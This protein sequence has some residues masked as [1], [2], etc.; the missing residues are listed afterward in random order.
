MSEELPGGE[1]PPSQPARPGHQPPPPGPQPP[2]QPPP[3]GQQPPQPGHQQPFWHQ[4]S[5]WGPAAP[6]GGPGAHGGY[7]DY[8]WYGGGSAPSDGIGGGPGSPRTGLA[9]LLV[10]LLVVAAVAGVAIGYAAWHAPSRAPSPL[11]PP[12]T[13]PHSGEGTEAPG[14]P[15]DAGAIAR[16]T[17]PGLVDIDTVEGYQSTEGA[18]TGMVLSSS[19]VVLT[20]NHVVEEATSFEVRDVG[21]GKTYKATVLGYD[22]SQDVALI[23]LSGASDLQTVR[24]GTTQTVRRGEGVVAVG[25]AEGLG[26][27]PSYAGGKI[28]ALDQSITAEDEIN[29]STEQLTGLLATDAEIVPGDS[30]GALVDENR[31]VIGMTT[32]GSEGYEGFQ[33]PTSSSV[34][35]AVPITTAMS[36]AQQILAGHSSSTVHVGP[37]AFLGVE[38]QSPTSGSGAEIVAVVSGGPAAKAGLGPGDTITSVAGQTVSSPKALTNVLA[39]ETPG[40]SVPVTYVQNGVTSTVTVQLGS[41]PAQ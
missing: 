40:T 31:L 17:D 18:A 8:G 21:N 11:F 20:N 1:Q 24:L 15:A 2:W 39:G 14:S 16:A 28:T 27:T 19:G 22:R 35:Y 37:T 9:T 7:G 26:G 36:T 29:D 23:R 33:L 5:S 25:N 12:T 32:A 6:Q 30:G 41:G 13:I 10:V 3:P 38:V 34:G 4:Q